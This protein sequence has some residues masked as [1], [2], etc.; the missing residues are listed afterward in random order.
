VPSAIALYLHG[1]L[2]YSA[3]PT[4]TTITTTTTTTIL[5]HRKLRLY[6]ASHCAIPT[7]VYGVALAL[8]EAAPMATGSSVQ[9]AGLA[10]AL[11]WR[12]EGLGGT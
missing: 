3:R 12:R 5:I 9:T 4:T 6:T 8:D 1:N 11:A 7:T 10:A 2:D